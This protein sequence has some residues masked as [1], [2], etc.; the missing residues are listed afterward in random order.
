MP[1]YKS[2]LEL[3]DE[4]HIEYIIYMVSQSDWP[5]QVLSDLHVA[6]LKERQIYEPQIR[7]PPL[8]EMPLGIW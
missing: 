2:N 7:F 6:Y 5:I 8:V 1:P 3:R 4:R